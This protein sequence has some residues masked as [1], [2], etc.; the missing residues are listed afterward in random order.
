MHFVGKIKHYSTN[1]QKY[2]E[3]FSEITMDDGDKPGLIKILKLLEKC[4]Y[5][6]FFWSAV[7]RIQTEH[8]DLQ[9]KSSYLV[10]IRENA[11]Q[12]KSEYGYF[13]WSVIQLKI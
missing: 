13:L 9:S 3:R 12:K 1:R 10:R 6:E 7:S 4:P 5:S 11:D 8:G 2:W